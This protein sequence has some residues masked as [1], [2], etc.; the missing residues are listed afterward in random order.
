[1]PGGWARSLE[2]I[3]AD[4]NVN[5]ID[6][7]SYLLWFE[8]DLTPHL[9]INKPPS[10]E[11]CRRARWAVGGQAVCIYGGQFSKFLNHIPDARTLIGIDAQRKL[12]FLGVFDCASEVAAAHFFA[13]H[14]VV[15]AILLDGGSSTCLAIGEGATGIVPRTLVYPERAL[16]TVFG[17]R[18]D[19]DPEHALSTSAAS[20]NPR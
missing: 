19:Q 16:A 3:I 17:I 7:N 13:A 14:G 8:D 4:H 12:L 6:P 20:M 1:L 15:D 2:T 5:H 11:L 9:E 10:A 18:A